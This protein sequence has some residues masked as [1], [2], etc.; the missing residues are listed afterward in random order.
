MSTLPQRGDTAPDFELPAS[1]GET[2]TLSALRGKPVVLFF[3]PKDNTPGCTREACGFRDLKAA[4][5]KAGVHVFGVSA[6]SLESHAR[7]IEGQGLNF[8]LLS[9]PSHAMLT[10][11]GVWGEKKNYG[12]T[13][14]GT[15]RA[16][17]LIDRR[18]VVVRSWAKVN[19]DDHA[20]MV[21]EAAREL[22]GH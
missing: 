5:D 13:Y 19:V 22:A 15:T 7:F 1:T 4:F 9:D 8:P 10:A 2:I 6:D 20:E 21:L 17:V 3:Y 18:G 11:Y 14:M 16:T 12:R